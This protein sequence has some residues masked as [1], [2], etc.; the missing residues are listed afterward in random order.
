M[1]AGILSAFLGA[2]TLL[3][4]IQEVRATVG[5]AISSGE[6]V[7]DITPYRLALNW[8]IGRIWR[9]DHQWGLNA[10]WEN[11]M[12]YWDAGSIPPGAQGDD[13]NDELR[14]LT[15]GPVF[16]WQ[17][18][19]LLETLR[20]APYFEAGIG[21][22]W[23]SRRSIGGRHLSL[24]FQFEDNIGVGFRF[25]KQQQFDLTLRGFHYSNASL[26][27][28]NSGVNIAMLSFGI[29]L[30]DWAPKNKEY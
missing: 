4:P 13:A 25:G 21:L 30:V 18:K 11:S 7:Q 27:R 1:R 23:L 16:R 19:E 20:I 8:D 5:L 9:H 3:Q 22:S 2:M 28:P 29:W 15:T 10:I 26:K 24:H 6:G 12:A 17:R 14:A